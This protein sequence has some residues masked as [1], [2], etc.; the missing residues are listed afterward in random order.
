MIGERSISTGMRFTT[1]DMPMKILFVVPY[2]PNPIRVRPYE[3]LRTLAA[4]CHQITVAT[5]WQS[6]EERSE[7]AALEALGITVI[8]QPLPRLRSL[9]NSSIALPTRT[10]LQARYCWQPALATMLRQIVR[11]QHFDVAHV[12]HLRGAAYGLFLRTLPT[13][14]GRPLPLVWD[15]VDCISHLFAQAAR[16]SRSLGG[17]LMTTLELPRTRRYEGWLLQQFDQVLVTSKTDQQALCA[18]ANHPIGAAQKTQQTHGTK[19]GRHI[20]EPIVISNGVDLAK[21]AP[22]PPITTEGQ[23]N[24]REGSATVLFSGK[25]SYHANVTAAL[26]LVNEIMPHVWATHPEIA[27]QIVGKDPPAQIRALATADAQRATQGNRGKV[28]VTGTVPDLRPYLQQATIAAAPLLYGAGIQNKVL[29]AMA[30][31]VPVIT[32]GQAAGGMRAEPGRD[33]VVADSAEQF[34]AAIIRLVDNRTERRAVG[35]AGRVYV[36]AHHSWHAIVESLEMVYQQAGEQL[37]TT[38]EPILPISL[39]ADTLGN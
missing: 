11:E 39:V 36:E 2:V 17:R 26:Y 29:E 21:F 31:G 13:P 6:E 8:A 23:Y 9:W 24:Q 33:L 25:M 38:A 10:P 34:A 3:I 35:A 5:L 28:I 18:L 27:V 20:V 16:Q 12:E 14:S 7:I 37:V 4:R 30:C 32:T 1:S 15:S 22:L 19:N